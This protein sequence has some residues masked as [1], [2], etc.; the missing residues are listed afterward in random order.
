MVQELVAAASEREEP[1]DGRNLSSEAL[2]IYEAEIIARIYVSVEKGDETSARRIVR[3]HV[4]NSWIIGYADGVA[5]DAGHFI[6]KGLSASVG[7]II[8]F[9]GNL[10]VSKLQGKEGIF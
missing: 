10:R 8:P 4:A 1:S 2:V 3:D 7:A 5:Q 6:V 9:V